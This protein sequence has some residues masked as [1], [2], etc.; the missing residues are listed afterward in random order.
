MSSG[1][2]ESAISLTDIPSDLLLNKICPALDSKSIVFLLSTARS[3]RRALRKQLLLDTNVLSDTI[4][5]DITRFDARQRVLL[6]D[7]S[8]FQFRSKSPGVRCAEMQWLTL[9]ERG[10]GN[11]AAASCFQIAKRI[12]V[13]R[14]NRRTEQVLQRS[15]GDLPYVSWIMA[16]LSR[17]ASYIT[18]DLVKFLDDLLPLLVPPPSKRNRGAGARRMAMAPPTTTGIS[19]S[20]SQRSTKSSGFFGM[21]HSL[22]FDYLLAVL[23]GERAYLRGRMEEE[24]SDFELLA[25]AIIESSASVHSLLTEGKVLVKS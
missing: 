11:L 21:L 4:L 16:W 22:E 1:T 10:L 5:V 17:Y 7:L 3:V 14:I 19:S 2:S 9:E 15:V 12:A 6:S 20:T 23:N 18:V 8:L 24:V 25:N 13:L